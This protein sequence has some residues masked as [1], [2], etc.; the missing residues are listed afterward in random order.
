MSYMVN[1]NTFNKIENKVNQ[2]HDLM[3]IFANNTDLDIDNLNPGHQ[4]DVFNTYGV[5][6][7]ISTIFRVV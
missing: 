7:Y 4:K 5:Y 3:F 1:K 2:L 6:Q